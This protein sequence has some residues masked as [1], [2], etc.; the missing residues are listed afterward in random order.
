MKAPRCFI[1]ALI[2]LTRCEHQPQNDIPM[3]QSLILLRFDPLDEE[4]PLSRLGYER[5]G[6]NRA[7]VDSA[8]TPASYTS[9]AGLT[10][11]RFA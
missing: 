10:L 11:C 5:R 3:K 1:P 9:W 7:L 2:Q 4:Q 8:F 6:Q